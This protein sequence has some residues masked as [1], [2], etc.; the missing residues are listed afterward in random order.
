MLGLGREIVIQISV[1]HYLCFLGTQNLL[2]AGIGEAITPNYNLRFE[3][4]YAGCRST[5]ARVGS[6]QGTVPEERR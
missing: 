3:V 2:G 4:A 5:S 1:R 6:G